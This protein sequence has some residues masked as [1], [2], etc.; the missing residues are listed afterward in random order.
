M[1]NA[2]DIIRVV[3]AGAVAGGL[4]VVEIGLVRTVGDLGAVT[5]V[6]FHVAYDH[7]VEWSMPPLTIATLIVGIVDLVFHAMPA[8][9]KVLSIAGLVAL[10]TVAGISQLVNVPMNATMRKWEPGTA[11]AEYASIRRRWDRAHTLRTLAGQV[12]L[13][14]FAA[15]LVSR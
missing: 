13:V 2:L 9:A 4:L 14:C 6:R 8:G 7:Y 11:P 5:G 10:A 3:L 1:A 12:A 15:A